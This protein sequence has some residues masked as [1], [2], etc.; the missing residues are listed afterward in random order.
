MS[1]IYLLASYL[2][3]LNTSLVSENYS[4]FPLLPHSP[5]HPNHCSLSNF[6]FH[7]QDT[8]SEGFLLAFKQGNLATFPTV[9]SLS[10]VCRYVYTDISMVTFWP[11]HPYKIVYLVMYF[12][13]YVL[14]L[15]VST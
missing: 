13:L 10:D 2:T 8:E 3:S 15:Y 9:S 6:A 12:Y 11:E 7:F 14:L 1:I 4:S 5:S